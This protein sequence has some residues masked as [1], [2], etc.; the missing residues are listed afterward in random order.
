[1]NRIL[2]I[3]SYF[4]LVNMPPFVTFQ[5]HSSKYF[6]QY[7]RWL[8]FSRICFSNL[9]KGERHSERDA[10]RK[11][12]LDTLTRFRDTSALY[13]GSVEKKRKGPKGPQ[14]GSK[15]KRKR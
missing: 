6:L 10:I 7:S 2:L 13:G 11:S 5:S 14:A 12:E 15:K 4:V 9:K 8:I 3:S 1:M